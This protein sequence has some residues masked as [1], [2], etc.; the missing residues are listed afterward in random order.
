MLVLKAEYGYGQVLG[1]HAL[2]VF[3]KIVSYRSKCQHVMLQNIHGAPGLCRT[4]Q[5][6]C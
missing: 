2:F 4:G 5:H 6:V 3:M 1:H